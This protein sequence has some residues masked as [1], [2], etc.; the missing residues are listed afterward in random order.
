MLYSGL[1]LTVRRIAE[2]Y[3]QHI[4]ETH[5]KHWIESKEIICYKR[6]VDDILII[7][8]H[9]KTN[10]IAITNIMNSISE[11]LEFKA[12]TE[13]NRSINYLDLTINRNNNS[14]ELSI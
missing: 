11:H 3:L 6:Y 12:T 4:E 9:S 14:M 13:V 2:I 10:E 8:D 5:I 1:Q 7:F